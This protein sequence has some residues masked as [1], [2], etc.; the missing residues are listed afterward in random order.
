MS[1]KEKKKPLLKLSKG[2]DL[3]LFIA[4]IILMIF[5]LVMVGSASMG[6]ATGNNMYLAIAIGKQFA[7][8]F[9][10]YIAMAILTNRFS[11]NSLTQNTVIGLVGGTA[12]L[13]LFCLAFKAVDGARA[14]IRIPLGPQEVTLQPSE[15]AKVVSI[16]LI[17]AYI[18]DSKSKKNW[19]HILSRPVGIIL[20]FILIV[21]I[22]QHDFGSAMVIFLIASVCLLIPENPNLKVFRIVMR[23]LFWLAVAASVYLLS[24]YGIELIR[25]IPFIADY[26]VNR[27]ETALDPF[28]DPY[29]NSY[30]LIIG[31]TAFASGGWFGLGLGNSIRKYTRFPAANTDYILAV[32]VEELGFAGFCVLMLLYGI[33]I[34]R[35]LYFAAKIKNEKA[36]I[37]LVGTAMYVLVHI[38]FNIG[39]VTGLLPLT[40][41]PLLMVSAG[42]S[43]IMAFMCAIGLSQAMISAWRRGEIE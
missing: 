35:L 25:K 18:G 17:A 13:L 29:G 40:G 42:G 19:F 20:A 1:R 5:G 39:G 24:P 32:L 15:F 43:S 6:L 33:L 41:I 8:M 22:L 11:L 10:G 36:R 38:F 27:F 16:L 37:I 12:F 7:F 9:A 31:M 14:W 4:L 28:S 34:C 3:P 26:Q 21:L 30:Q 2:I 23:V